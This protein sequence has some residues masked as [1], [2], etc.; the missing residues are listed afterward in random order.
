M[1]RNTPTRFGWMAIA[2]HWLIAVVTLALFVLGLYMVGLGYMDRWYH[3]A[4]TIHQGI[5]MLLLAA[6]AWRSL[7]ALLNPKPGPA[8]PTPAWAQRAAG[9]AHAAMYAL[10]LAVPVTGYLILSAD[11]RGVDVFGWFTVPALV[12][13]LSHHA[14]QIAGRAHLDLAVAL[15]AIAAAHAA[16]A[17]KHH[18]WNRDATLARM[19]G[20]N[21]ED[22]EGES[23][24]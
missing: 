14:A 3:T 20:R 13:H 16:A 7:W 6:I 19:L 11:G 21:I 12:A 8:A 10:L 24:P 18:L 22:H 1:I 17:V 5:G 23:R 4:P 9:L 15:I 2:L